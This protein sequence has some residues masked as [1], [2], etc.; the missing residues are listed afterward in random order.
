MRVVCRRST[1]E[2]ATVCTIH[3]DALA[4]EFEIIAAATEILAFF[5]MLQDRAVAKVRE[6]QGNGKRQEERARKSQPANQAAM[7]CEKVSFHRFLETKGP[8]SPVPDKRAADTRMKA[9]LS[10]SSKTQLNDDR[11][12]L[13]RFRSLRADYDAWMRGAS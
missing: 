6:L 7:L 11:T 9:L 10:I 3:P 4:V 8:G 2:R 5:L 1:G 13:A 12:A